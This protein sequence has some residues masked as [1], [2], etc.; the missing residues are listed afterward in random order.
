MK[1]VI[2]E[3]GYCLNLS[4]KAILRLRELG[5]KGALKE[6]LVGEYYD[7]SNPATV[8]ESF[9]RNIESYHAWSGFGPRNDPILLRVFEEMGD[10]ACAP[11]WSPEDSFS[12]R[13]IEIP[14]DVE[15]DVVQGDCGGEY[16]AEKHRTWP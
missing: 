13:I 12:F 8:R 10:E 5:H 4:R 15:F 11:M 1:V 14:D 3:D 6:T 7:V 9:I 2:G 16:I